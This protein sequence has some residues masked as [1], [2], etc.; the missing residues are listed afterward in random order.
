[1]LSRDSSVGTA[2]GLRARRPAFDFR[3]GKEILLFS[4][5]SRRV[6]GPTQP[7]IRRVPA[8]LSP[9]LKRPGREADHSPPTSAEAK[10]S[11][12]IPVLPHT[13]SRPGAKLINHRDNFTFNII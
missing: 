4:T 12:A 1:V 13:S 5:V 8:T 9:G 7:P 6:L 2:I 3:Q 10:N 11:G